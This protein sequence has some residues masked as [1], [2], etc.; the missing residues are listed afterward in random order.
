MI[1]AVDQGSSC[2]LV[3]AGA[4]SEW[5]PTKRRADRQRET[6]MVHGAVWRPNANRSDAL[7]EIEQARSILVVDNEQLICKAIAMILHGTNFGVQT[8]RSETEALR[9]VAARIFDLVLLD[10]NL[11]GA[12]RGSHACR[13]A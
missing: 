13:P 6:R 4:P 9:V 12:E 7:S 11:P 1:A 10:V 5:T 2:V 3:S 8:A